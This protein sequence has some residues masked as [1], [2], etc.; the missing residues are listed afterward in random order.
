[1][2]T[3]NQRGRLALLTSGT[4]GS[5]HELNAKHDG[6]AGERN[7]VATSATGIVVGLHSS[8]ILRHQQQ[9]HASPPPPL[10]SKVKTSNGHLIPYR[11]QQVAHHSVKSR[12]PFQLLITELLIKINHHLSSSII[13]HPTSQQQKRPFRSLEQIATSLHELFLNLCRAF[14]IDSGADRISPQP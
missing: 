10:R 5:S 1:M 8:L 9:Q 6:A 4:V 12:G 3:C 13:K 7:S 11:P 14:L 2:V